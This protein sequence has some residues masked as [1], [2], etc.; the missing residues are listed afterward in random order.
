MSLLVKWTNFNFLVA[1][2]QLKLN[3]YKKRGVRVLA[4]VNTIT[5]AEEA[6]DLDLH[7]D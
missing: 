6:V 1:K 7:P 4:T 3:L 2:K 5:Q